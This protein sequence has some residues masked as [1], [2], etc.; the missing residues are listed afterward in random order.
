MV[1]YSKIP[2]KNPALKNFSSGRKSLLTDIKIQ[3]KI[4]TILVAHP[5]FPLKN[6][7]FVDR[8]NQLAGI[9]KYVAE[10]QNPVIVIGDLNV[11]MWSP[12][13]KSMVETGGLRN[14]RSGFG[15]LP[16][17]PTY[18]PLISIP[19]DHC[20]VS[21]DIQV[22]NIR[23]GRQVGSDHLPLITDLVINNN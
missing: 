17:W 19:I 5:P 12:F 13:Y 14:A 6:R 18:R 20:L 8:N 4:I 9:G 1:I 16:T 3:G 2:L 22:L 15:I 10:A 21:G 23:L 7:T 11:T